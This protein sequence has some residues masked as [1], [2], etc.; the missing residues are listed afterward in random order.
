MLE[1]RVMLCA[2]LSS[3]ERVIR[4]RGLEVLMKARSNPHLPKLKLLRG[5]RKLQI[6]KINWDAE[7]WDKVVDIESVPL[8]I[9][10][11]VSQI[12][13]EEIQR[14]KE[15]P[16][17]FSRLPI[18][19]TSVERAVKLVSESSGQV[20]GKE[21]RHNFILQKL[22]GRKLIPTFNN[23]REFKVVK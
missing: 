8:A 22:G 19:S 12:P 18:H 4:E 13:E 9:P 10:F 7:S 20:Y 21:K 14:I 15:R 5:I 6:P 23:K 17:M 1:M 3:E 2:M 16:H 11:I